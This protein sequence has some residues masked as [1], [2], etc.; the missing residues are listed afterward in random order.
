MLGT[1]KTARFLS[2]PLHRMKT[3]K[4]PRCANSRGHGRSLSR[5]PDMG[6]RTG[7]GH[8]GISL[9]KSDWATL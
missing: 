5:R 9:R 4:P 7:Q 6:Q 3:L 8:A 1:T 2:A